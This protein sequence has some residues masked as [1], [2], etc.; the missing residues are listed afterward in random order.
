M[1]NLSKN[2]T[3]NPLTMENNILDTV[4][5]GNEIL[6]KKIDRKPIDPFILINIRAPAFSESAP[7]C[8]II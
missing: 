6:V 7:H 2:V 8:V 4:N 3:N 5:L 1:Y